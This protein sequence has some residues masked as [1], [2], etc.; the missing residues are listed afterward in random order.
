MLQLER[1]QTINHSCTYVNYKVDSLRFEGVA[2]HSVQLILQSGALPSSMQK[3]IQVAV[4]NIQSG[5]RC[6]L[7]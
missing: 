4:A 6:T 3:N 5:L 2:G 1:W 7:Q